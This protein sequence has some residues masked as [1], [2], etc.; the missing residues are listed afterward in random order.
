MDFNTDQLRLA[1]RELRIRDLSPRTRKS[2][3][4]YLG[5]YFDFKKYGFDRLNGENIK[6]FLESE[7]RK[8][9][10]A[11]VRNLELNAIKFF[12]RAVVRTKEKVII[13]ST[14]EY[15]KLPTVLTKSEIE[16]IIGVTKN[17]KHKLILGLAYG[18]DLRVNGAVDIKAQDIN[19]KELTVAIR[20]SKGQ[21][22]RISILSEKLVDNIKSLCVGSH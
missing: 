12:C 4:Y 9:V 15:T 17:I 21:K 8:G 2:Y 7:E 22:D 19:P 6:D 16:K 1:E 11:Q 14:R 18:A 10:S 13:K 20:Q 3:L 5:R